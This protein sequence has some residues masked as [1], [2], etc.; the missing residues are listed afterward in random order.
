MVLQ[1]MLS[2]KLLCTAPPRSTVALSRFPDRRLANIVLYRCARMKG[3]QQRRPKKNRIS[4]KKN[5]TATRGHQNTPFEQIHFWLAAA[6]ERW[7]VTGSSSVWSAPTTSRLPDCFSTSD[8]NM[9]AALTDMLPHGT[10]TSQREEPG[11]LDD[12]DPLRRGN[13]R[14]GIVCTALQL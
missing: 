2:W 13:S 11:A 8:S 3:R 5:M 12:R 6:C 10:G 7:L 9:S 1:Y 4:K 14:I